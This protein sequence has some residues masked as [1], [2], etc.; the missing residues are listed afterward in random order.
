MAV[1]TRAAYQQLDAGHVV[2]TLE[3]LETRMAARFPER[4]IGRVAGEL[5]GVIDEAATLGRARSTRDQI[6]DA[7]CRIGAAIV[8]ALAVGALVLSVRDA[9]HSARGTPAFEWLPVVESGI[10]DTVF[11]GI[12]VYFLLSIPGRRQRG[13]TLAVLYRL[14]SL[15]HVVDMHQLTKDPERLRP[16]FAPTDASPA[17][18]LTPDELGRYLDYC[19]ELLSLVSKAAALCSQASTDA[20]VLDTVSEIE[21]LTVGMSR[22][23]WQKISLIRSI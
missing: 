19:S 13:R 8:V 3:R 21:T 15:A 11:A 20:V 10:N 9:T 1:G 12:A 6:V 2:R 5:R 16:D 14:R 17:V 4:N 23:I 22:K 18:D 7:A